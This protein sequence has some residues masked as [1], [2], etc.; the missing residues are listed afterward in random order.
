M[1]RGSRFDSVDVYHEYL[2]SSLSPAEQLYQTN[3]DRLNLY[4]THVE[5]VTNYVFVTPQPITE[6]SE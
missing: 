6:T 1:L 2:T 3:R 4:N 5:S